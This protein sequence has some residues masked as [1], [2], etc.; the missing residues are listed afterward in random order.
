LYVRKTTDELQALLLELLDVLVT[1]A[2]KSEGAAMPAYTHLQAAEPVLV[3]HW[4]LAYAEMFVRDFSRLADC[5]KRLNFCPLGSGA[6]AGA[7]LE[8]ERTAIA[9][10]L[11]FTA[12]TANSMDATSDRDFAI[13]FAQVL[14]LL[15][16]H[17][18]RWAEE[19]IIFSSQAYGFVRLPESYSTGSSAM[20][21]KK[22]PDAMEL[23][24]GK[25]ARMIGNAVSLVVT[26]KGLPLAYNKDLQETQ[27]PVFIAAE[28]AIQSL[29]AAVGFTRQV[30]FDFERMQSAAQSGFMNALAAATYLVNKGTSFRKAHEQIGNAVCYCLEKNCELGDLSLEELRRFSPEFAEDFYSCLK[31]DAVLACHNVM[32]GTH[33]ARVREALAKMRRQISVFSGEV[34]AHA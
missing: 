5:R 7:P 33:P 11:G 22:N 24:R 8:L 13:E 4:L 34:H 27:E 6:I 15:F 20:P 28:T 12:P 23:I 30:E 14:S 26:L 19:M 1:R 16:V 32:G 2:E 17:L 9:E 25:A 10:E 21:Q 18:S 3:A 29:R 31:L